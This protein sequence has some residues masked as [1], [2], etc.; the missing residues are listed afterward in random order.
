MK[1][2]VIGL[3][4]LIISTGNISNANLVFDQKNRFFFFRVRGTLV[5]T[6]SLTE[7]FGILLAYIIGNYFD[8]YA[9]PQFTIVLT[10]L[11]GILLCFFPE[12]PLILVKQEKIA[13]STK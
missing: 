9:T 12:S 10:T 8:F 4:Q 5:S 7:N 3:F 13:V 6:L 1:F 11:F 2:Q